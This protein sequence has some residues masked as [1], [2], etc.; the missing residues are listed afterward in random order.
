MDIHFNDISSEVEGFRLGNIRTQKSFSNDDIRKFINGVNELELALETIVS[1]RRLIIS[2][3]NK[4]RFE[5]RDY[6]VLKINNDYIELLIQYEQRSEHIIVSNES[7]DI[8]LNETTVGDEFYK[9][10]SHKLNEIGLDIRNN[11][12]L[13]SHY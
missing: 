11:Q 2:N 6:Y 3:I 12:T 8:R 5:K 4:K 10:I 13:I 9:K 1:R 7:G